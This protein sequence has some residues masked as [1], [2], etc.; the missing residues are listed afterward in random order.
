MG[1]PLRFVDWVIYQSPKS[2]PEEA[3]I[4]VSTTCNFSC[5]HCFRYAVKGFEERIMD[6][7]LFKATLDN[8]LRAGVKRVVFTGLGE[9]MLNPYILEMVELSKSSG[10]SVALNTN[11][12]RLPELAAELVKLSVDEI[13][14]SVDAFDPEV[15][16]RI[17]AGGDIS[18]L[19]EGL[20]ELIRAKLQRGRYRPIVK[21]IFTVNKLNVGEVGKA[22]DY[23]LR[24]GI[25]EVIFSYYIHYPAGGAD[26]DCLNDAECRSAFLR[27]LSCALYK[28]LETGVRYTKPVF[29]PSTSRAC[30]FASNR[31]LFIRCDGA[32]APCIYYSRS[33][34]TKIMG[35]RREIKEVILGNVEVDELI[36]V[37]RNCYLS[38]YF[39]LYFKY[40]P[41]CFD[42]QLQRYC[43]LT[44][45]NEADC[46]GHSPTCAHCPY[47]HMLSYC[48][49]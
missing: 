22:L 5:L 14:V 8:A 1:F 43:S 48:P 17:R 33:W 28:Q 40:F 31:A 45:S 37:W 34:S 6:I 18:V 25:S 27:E 23:A 36:N 19:S 38:M 46:W 3:A 26:L 12:F 16:A 39:K 7:D 49:L 41:S 9:P 21:A 15:Y 13:F 24:H 11:G 47:F 35:I 4:E 29:P 42:C 30:P 20:N 2:H 44:R 10:L 32:V